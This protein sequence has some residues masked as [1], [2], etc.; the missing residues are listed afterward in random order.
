MKVMGELESKY[1]PLDIVEK[2]E[3]VKL[4]YSSL[5]ILLV[6]IIIYTYLYF[7]TCSDQLR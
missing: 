7:H 2:D 5:F 3:H 4:Q 1:N 6:K